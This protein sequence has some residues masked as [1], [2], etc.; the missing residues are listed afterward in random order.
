MNNPKQKPVFEH[1]WHCARLLKSDRHTCRS[2]P[3]MRAGCFI[4]CL[5]FFLR[6]TC[7][8]C[9]RNKSVKMSVQRLQTCVYN[10][11]DVWPHTLLTFLIWIVFLGLDSQAPVYDQATCSPPL[12]FNYNGG[13]QPLNPTT[14]H[15]H[16]LLVLLSTYRKCNIWDTL[17][18]IASIASQRPL[19]KV[20]VFKN[21]NFQSCA[22]SEKQ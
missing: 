13:Q 14:H 4:A 12:H 22:E 17:Q 5:F 15:L 2:G 7:W 20:L 8:I 1:S 16:P 21:R 10:L 11:S 9:E 18:P 6:F 19:L 3:L